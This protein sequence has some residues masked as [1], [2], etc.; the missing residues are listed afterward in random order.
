M[1]TSYTWPVKSTTT[2]GTAEQPPTVAKTDLEDAPE[3]VNLLID[4]I[5]TALAEVKRQ[6][7]SSG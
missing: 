3:W 6:A 7:E 2:A 5:N 1:P 4:R